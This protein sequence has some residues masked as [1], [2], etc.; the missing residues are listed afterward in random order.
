MSCWREFFDAFAP[1]Y[2][3]EVFT[4]NTEAEVRFLQEHLRVP[5]GGRILD[6]GCGTGRH[7]VAL[8]SAGF[9]LTGVDL[10]GGMLEVAKQRAARA[11]VEAEWIR[12]NAA[13]FVRPDAFDA[14]ICLCEGAMCLFSS[15]DDPLERDMVLLRNMHAS[16]RSGGRL[17]LNV[18]NA[19]RQ[20][21]LFN[22][23]DIASGR[24]D[25]LTL[26]ERSDA[27]GLLPDLQLPDDMR[28]RG[29]T[30][31]ELH[32]M[33]RWVGFEVVGIYGGTAGDWGIRPPRLDEYELMAIAEKPRA[34]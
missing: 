8:A 18:L 20:I 11:G 33:L 25:M 17:I 27:P 7:S 4:K 30:A 26:S 16:L 13:D 24:F 31:P 10:S 21:R 34:G 6:V 15:D 22:D 14:I 12:A 1:R 19:C 32:R 5:R 2:D 3:E 23:D 9:C 28:E 29:Y